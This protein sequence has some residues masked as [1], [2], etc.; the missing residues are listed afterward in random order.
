MLNDSEY[1]NFITR[2]VK[3]CGEGVSGIDLGDLFWSTE[4][5]RPTVSVNCSDLF[6]WACADAEELTPENVHVFEKAIAD[7]EAVERNASGRHAE[8]LFACRIRQQR[9]QGPVYDGIPSKFWSLFD[10]CGSEREVSMGNPSQHPSKRLPKEDAKECLIQTWRDPGRK[11]YCTIGNLLWS[12]AHNFFEAKFADGFEREKQFWG[13]GINTES[14]AKYRAEFLA[15]VESARHNIKT[16]ADFKCFLADF[17]CL[18]HFTEPVKLRI[19]DPQLQLNKTFTWRVAQPE[20]EIWSNRCT[21][22]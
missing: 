15:K 2:V 8:A 16:D 20:D 21:I 3:A 12:P 13:D 5:G 7:I 11:E 10:A 19:I 18:I 17:T 1:L 9:P 14:Y 6:C 22:S 4:D